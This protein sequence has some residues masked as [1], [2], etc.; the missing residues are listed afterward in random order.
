M[1]ARPVVMSLSSVSSRHHEQG[2]ALVAMLAVMS[3]LALLALAAV[4]SVQQQ[5]QR[6]REKE[7]LFRG[8]QVADAI[9]SYYQFRAQYGG[10]QGLN[11]L[12]TS[13]DQL[14]EGIQIPGRTKKLQILR[15]SATRDPLSQDGEWRLIGPTSEDF[16]RFVRDLTVYTGGTP[17]TPRIQALAGLVPRA[18]NILNTDSEPAPG[19]ENTSP[20]ASGPFIG[21]SSRS[22][23]D[24]VI[25]YF[26]I[27]RH[28]HWI[29]TPMFR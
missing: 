19:G 5:T 15:V 12:P 16:A 20:D 24:S 4:P 10:A 3:L 14:A 13:I 23:R 22:Q 11:A 18:V 17:P 6:E 21:V 25:T 7:A 8:E 9:R 27:E 28:D 29:F 26:G 1:G 2:Y